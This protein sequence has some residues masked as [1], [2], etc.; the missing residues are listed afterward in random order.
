MQPRACLFSAF[1][2]LVIAGTVRAAAA[3]RECT[4]DKQWQDAFNKGDTS[5]V[6]ALY[7]S[8][9]V[10]VTPTGI[11]GGQGAV[12]ARLDESI[13][14]GWKQDLVIVATQCDSEGAVRWS[15]GSWEQT[16]PQGSPVGGFW[17]AIEVKDGNGW[18]I[19][20][21]TFNLTPPGLPNIYDIVESQC[22]Q[23]ARDAA[24]FTT[25]VTGGFAAGRQ[26]TTTMPVGAGER[27]QKFYDAC[28]KARMEASGFSNYDRANSQ[29]T[30]QAKAKVP[31][32]PNGPPDGGAF[33][34]RQQ[35]YH[36]CMKAR[37]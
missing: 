28:M 19:Q 30:Q 14:Q 21:F 36:A 13:K 24:G 5:A 1:S 35:V 27:Q 34:A 2:I 9:A 16:S 6:A 4:S 32:P 8:Q 11:Q 18:K 25:K 15:S 17:T 31:L 22:M 26:V 23:Q 12:K 7:T 20:N 37:L 10:E 33:V 3:E 29:C